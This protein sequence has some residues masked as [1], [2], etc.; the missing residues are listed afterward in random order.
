MLTKGWG[1]VGKRCTYCKFTYIPRVLVFFGD[2]GGESEDTDPCLGDIGILLGMEP[3]RDVLWLR[4]AD[5]LSGF[6][7]DFLCV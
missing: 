5:G 2:G 1:G 4:F 6:L 7:S 3:C